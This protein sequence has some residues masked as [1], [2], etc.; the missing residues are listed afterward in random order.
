M[1]ERLSSSTF[2][3]R[4]ERRVWDCR[5]YWSRSMSRSEMPLLVLARMA[6]LLK[7]RTAARDMGKRREDGNIEGRIVMYLKGLARIGSMV[8]GRGITDEVEIGMEAP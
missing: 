3:G 2:G 7:F 6:L 8:L 1:G 4:W 5:M